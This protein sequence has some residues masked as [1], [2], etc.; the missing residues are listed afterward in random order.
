M[1]EQLQ[2]A[3]L[4]G[5]CFWCV[6]AV[7]QPLK[8]VVKVIPGYAGGTVPGIPTYRE[9]CSGLTGH[10]EVVEVH[11]NPEVISFE[12]LLQVFMTT[13]DPTQLNR[14]GGDVGTQ[15]RSV[16]FYHNPE[17]KSITEQV[18]KKSQPEFEG[19]IVTE[20]SPVPRFFSAESYHHNY[21]AQ[22]ADQG[23]CQYVITPKV[24]KLRQY[25]AALLK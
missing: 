5:G 1:S 3:T 17:Q 18:I 16:V 2:V 15:Y 4:G 12:T 13:H 20:I 11:F 9:V 10:A 25:Y 22:N 7:L 8:G 14:Q 6:E 19:P 23:Y 24:A 21:Y